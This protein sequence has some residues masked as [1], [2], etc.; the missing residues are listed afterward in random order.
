MTCMSSTSAYASTRSASGSPL[1]LSFQAIRH[2]LQ[3]TSVR[4]FAEKAPSTVGRS[5]SGQRGD[6]LLVSNGVSAE[7]CMGV[8]DEGASSKR[9]SH[10]GEIARSTSAVSLGAP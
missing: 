6:M 1:L 2:Q 8:G 9:T 10:R 3:E 7:G 5:L 4:H